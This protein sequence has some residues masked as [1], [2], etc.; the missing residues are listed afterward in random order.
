MKLKVVVMKI[1][2]NISFCSSQKYTSRDAPRC[3]FTLREHQTW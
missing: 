2:I 1:R 3:W